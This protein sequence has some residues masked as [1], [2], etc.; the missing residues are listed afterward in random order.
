MNYLVRKLAPFEYYRYRDHLK[1]L[2]DDSRYLRFGF[3]AKDPTID[4]ICT[5]VEKDYNKHTLFG[6][7]NS[8]LELI[9][10]AHVAL[11]NPTELAFSVLKEYQGQ[12]IGSKLVRRSIQFCRNF[13]IKEVCMV[14]LSTNHIV[15]HLCLKHGLRLTTVDGETL[16]H[17][18][19]DPPNFA[20]IANENLDN[21]LAAIDFLN[22]QTWR[23][24]SIFA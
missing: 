22:K 2:D 17:F 7:E 23:F 21:N 3:R 11:G 24:L 6:V 13:N 19:L 20:S 5:R 15:R 9:G 4:D 8:K 14:C 10:V 1:K 12:G 16:A 18:Q